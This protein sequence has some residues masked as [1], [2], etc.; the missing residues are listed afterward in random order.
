MEQMVR[1]PA[2]SL[3]LHEHQADEVLDPG[4]LERSTTARRALHELLTPFVEA[5]RDGKG[6]D[7]ISIFWRDAEELMGPGFTVRDVTS[8]VTLAFNAGA[9]TTAAMTAAGI[10]LL[11]TQPDL[12]HKVREGGQRTVA[13]FVEEALRLWGTLIFR[14]RY[15]K[16]DLTIGGVEIREG[17]MIVALSGAAQRDP[18]HYDHSSLVDLDRERPRDHFGFFRGPRQCPGRALARLELVTIFSVLL[19]RLQDIKLEPSSSQ[20]RFADLMLRRWKP[21]HAT[22]RDARR[23]SLGT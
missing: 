16:Q 6:E 21:L 22:F 12:Q 13:A 19:E 4:V 3:E 18:S 1:L 17:E 10:Y 9:D 15:A 14:P 8:Q 20:P 7:L 2:A 11:A 23:P 5:R